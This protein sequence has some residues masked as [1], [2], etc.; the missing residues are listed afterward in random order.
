MIRGYR[1]FSMALIMIISNWRA[2]AIINSTWSLDIIVCL[3]R[4]MQSFICLV[5]LDFGDATRNPLYFSIFE[6]I[7]V[8]IDFN[9]VSVLRFC[10]KR[11]DLSIECIR[12]WPSGADL[13]T[14]NKFQNVLV[15]IR[16]FKSAME[17]PWKCQFPIPRSDELQSSQFGP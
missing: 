15:C 9:A 13:T 7:S 17:I 5:R 1:E 8:W 10:C 3:F 12:Q 14:R 6:C 4:D 2:L 11:K 16:Y